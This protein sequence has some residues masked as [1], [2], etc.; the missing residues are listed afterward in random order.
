M[1]VE[2][3]TQPIELII[4]EPALGSFVWRLLETDADGANPK[5]LR[6]AFDPADTYELALAAGQRALHSE[7]R[8]RAPAQPRAQSA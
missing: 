5:I 6:D 8:R 1:Q 4:E 3:M 7:I 2:W